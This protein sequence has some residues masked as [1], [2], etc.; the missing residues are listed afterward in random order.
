MIIKNGGQSSDLVNGLVGKYICHSEHVLLIKLEDGSIKTIPRLK[1]RIFM[2][3]SSHV[4]YRIQFPIVNATAQTIQSSYPILISNTKDPNQNKLNFHK[5]YYRSDIIVERNIMALLHPEFTKNYIPI[6]TPPDGN[7][8]FHMISIRLFGHCKN[9]T[10][11]RYITVFFLY[12]IEI[13]VKEMIKKEIKLNTPNIIDRDL[14]TQSNFQY[15]KL[16]F[17]ARKS[18]NWCN[19]YHLW[20]ISSCLSITIYIYSKMRENILRLDNLEFLKKIR[21]NI[22]D[23]CH[24]IKYIPKTNQSKFYICG[25]FNEHHYSALLPLDQ[26]HTEFIPKNDFYNFLA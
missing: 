18:G 8:L 12:V 25:F 15:R 17:N 1:Q 4:F 10:L 26:I 21:T 7:C 16:L 6:K 14:D 11:I 23:V 13:T 22:S 5:H 3:N 24:A 9:S 2:K 20:A 19:E